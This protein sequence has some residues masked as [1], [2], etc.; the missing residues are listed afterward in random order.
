M[1]H[2]ILHTADQGVSWQISVKSGLE[3]AGEADSS[4]AGP[5]LLFASIKQQQPQSHS[6][7]QEQS[8]SRSQALQQVPQQ[9]QRMAVVPHH[10]NLPSAAA[11]DSQLQGSPAG[12]QDR[13]HA[14]Q[15]P[16]MPG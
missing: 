5:S 9:V 13:S 11:M 4:V 6:Q 10:A 3:E 2:S 12:L 7:A 1:C 16:A 8:Q 14:A 15:Q